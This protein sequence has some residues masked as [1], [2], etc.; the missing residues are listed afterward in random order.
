MFLEQQISILEWFLKDH[1]TLKT[2]VKKTNPKFDKMRKHSPDS[3]WA[4][5]YTQKLR[6]RF[7]WICDIYS[8]ILKLFKNASTLYLNI[9]I[10]KSLWP[11]DSDMPDRWSG[12]SPV[13]SVS[14]T[15][16]LSTALSRKKQIQIH[17]LLH[18]SS[19]HPSSLCVLALKRPKG[20]SLVYLLLYY[21]IKSPLQTFPLPPTDLP[22]CQNDGPV[23]KQQ[24]C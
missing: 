5:L 3:S 24:S 14:L 20:A 23:Q 21:G 1:V 17:S 8:T 19:C 16:P 7:L 2:G 10:L 11:Y 9:K 18:L 22:F 4:C 13:H 15:R 12:V 6:L